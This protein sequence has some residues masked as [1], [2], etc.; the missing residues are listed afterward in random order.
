MG[1]ELQDVKSH[2]RRNLCRIHARA[3]VAGCPRVSCPVEK[4]TA[5]T[6]WKPAT[7]NCYRSVPSL[8]LVR[9]A[10]LVMEVRAAI[11]KVLSPFFIRLDNAEEVNSFAQLEILNCIGATDGIPGACSLHLHPPAPGL[12]V[13]QQSYFT[14]GLQDLVDHHG[15][16][17]NINMEWSGNIH[18]ARIFRNPRVFCNEKNP[19]HL[20][21]Q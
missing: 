5:S 18:D 8:V 20:L 10:T 12:G 19:K 11:K 16:V 7:P 21:L 9:S 3:A 13:H 4:C 17:T 6:I 14:L 15:W 2:F 1:R